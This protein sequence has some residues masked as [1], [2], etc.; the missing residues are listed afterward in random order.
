ML[1]S[2]ILVLQAVR[3]LHCMNG[4]G[5]P[6]EQERS[7]S[8]STSQCARSGA[9][10]LAQ[11]QAVWTDRGLGCV[12]RGGSIGI[13]PLG[14]EQLLDSYAEGN[15][16]GRARAAHPAA[17]QSLIRVGS[18]PSVSDGDGGKGGSVQ[19]CARQIRSWI[20]HVAPKALDSL[21]RRAG[22]TSR[23]AW[24]IPVCCT[25]RTGSTQGSTGIQELYSRVGQ[26]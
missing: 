20:I 22:R 8:P 1:T 9:V 6:A 7:A 16:C 24:H 11:A 2:Y 5:V 15:L 13:L 10:G 19:A 26:A 21:L 14:L 18:A 25:G 3:S 12:R 17:T 4:S 23:S